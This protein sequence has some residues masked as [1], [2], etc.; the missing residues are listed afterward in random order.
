MDLGGLSWVIISGLC[1][2]VLAG[3]ILFAQT[4]NRV[5]S[6][7]EE[8]SEAGTRRLYQEE[9]RDHRGEI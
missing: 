7:T 6:R 3:A 4:R 9:D 1:V 8:E 5:S 2:L